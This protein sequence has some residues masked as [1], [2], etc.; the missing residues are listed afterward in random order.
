MSL[1]ELISRRD[2]LK[3]SGATLLGLLL[4]D[5]ALDPVGAAAT[6][7]QGRVVYLHL[8]VREG[9]SFQAK[10]IGS[11][12]RDTLVNILDQVVG[13]VESDYNRIWYRIGVGRYVYSGGVQ[14]V[15][16][17]FNP[18]VTDLPDSGVVGE[19][20]V[21]YT[22][23]AWGINSQTFPGPRLYYATAHWIKGLVVDRKDGSRWY[24]AYD[25]L[26]QA[27]YFLRA[28]AVHILST[29]E[30]A[31]ISPEVPVDEKRIVILLDRQ[32]LLAYEAD[33]LVYAARAATG[34]HGFETPAGLFHTFHK[35]PTAHMVGGADEFSMFDLPAIPWDSYLTDSGV[36]IHGTYWH[37]DF[38]HPHSHGCIN[39]SPADAKW[40]YRWTE[41]Q[42]PPG[43]RLVY[44]P[45]IGT[46]VQILPMAQMLV[47]GRQPSAGPA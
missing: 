27:D 46:L 19:L 23:S 34:Q 8:L 47:G 7:Q 18:V 9:P 6:S 10:S 38:G 15:R 44:E 39:L 22:D 24:Q 42:V 2:F 21:P 43:E 12:L 36:A 37:N 33:R 26:Y 30:L 17:E 11:F 32:E 35:R 13:G 14:P 20:T 4:P 1:S 31:P 28:E 3:L 5:T 41:P 45:G 29:E 40:V 16:T 25:Q